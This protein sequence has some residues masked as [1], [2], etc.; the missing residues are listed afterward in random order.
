MSCWWWVVWF[1]GAVVLEG[2]LIS[3]GEWRARSWQ[4]DPFKAVRTGSS[5]SSSSPHS[6]SRLPREGAAWLGVMC[7]CLGGP[8]SRHL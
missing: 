2:V 7:H 8:V 6:S 1:W 5:S 4:A 3:R